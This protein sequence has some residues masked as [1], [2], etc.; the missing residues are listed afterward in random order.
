MNGY[1]TEPVAG[2][3]F[4]DQSDK[5]DNNTISLGDRLKE[6]R[7]SMQLTRIEVASLLN[8]RLNVIEGL[9][10][11]DY[12][13][14]P[15]L[16]FAR[17]YLRSYAKLLKLPADELVIIFNKLEWTENKSTFTSSA[18]LRMALKRAPKKGH[19]IIAWLTLIVLVLIFAVAGFWGPIA[20]TLNSHKPDRIQKEKTISSVQP[21][22]E[23]TEPSV[24]ISS[25]QESEST[26]P[27]LGDLLQE[28]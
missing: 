5:F 15:R 21:A 3:E 24:N 16:V 12:S 13:C 23:R 7:E 28:G 8:L 6:R 14:L 2:A 19:S 9:E 17:G 22:L 1:L 4:S 27:N 20:K 18:P 25:T 26:L 10:N 11:N